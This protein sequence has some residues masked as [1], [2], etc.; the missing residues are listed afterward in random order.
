M[1]PRPGRVAEIVDIDLPSRRG[2]DVINT[3]EFGAY[4]SRIRAHFGSVGRID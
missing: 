3:P 1:T 4:V 2:L